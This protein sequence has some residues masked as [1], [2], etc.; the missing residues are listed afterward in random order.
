[1]TRNYGKI[2]SKIPQLRDFSKLRGSFVLTPFLVEIAA[3]ESAD[4][5]LSDAATSIKIGTR[6]WKIGDVIYSIGDQ[7]LT[8]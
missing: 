8:K 2:E 5:Q 4:P 7:A 3:A 6:V 1:M